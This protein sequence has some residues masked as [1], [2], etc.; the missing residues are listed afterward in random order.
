MG[1]DGFRAVVA[2][3]SL[4]GQSS[5]DLAHDPLVEPV[6]SATSPWCR[7]SVIVSPARRVGASTAQ[8]IAAT[9]QGL[10]LRE[11]LAHR[12]RTDAGPVK[13]LTAGELGDLRTLLQ[14]AMEDGPAQ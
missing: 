5:S 7:A 4:G 10:S 9:E 1:P 3:R 12:L 2:G 14:R 6:T 8:A 13:A 11:R